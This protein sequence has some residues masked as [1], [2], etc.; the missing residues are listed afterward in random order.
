MFYKGKASALRVGNW[1]YHP[2]QG[3]GGLFG[4]GPIVKLGQTHSDYDET[5]KIKPD[6]PQEQLY[7]LGTDPHQTQNLVNTEPD[8]AA[9]MK[10]LM[11]K[12]NEANRKAEVPLQAILAD[13]SSEM[14]KKLDVTILPAKTQ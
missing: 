7:N 12:Y 6:A 11:K 8:V 2:Q 4:T 10:A 14:A 5:G 3:P 1:S 9:V 13:L